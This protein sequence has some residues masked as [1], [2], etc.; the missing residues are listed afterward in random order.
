MKYS[1]ESTDR[2]TLLPNNV[3]CSNADS[4]IQHENAV[5][6]TTLQEDSSIVDGIVVAS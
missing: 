1:Q 2:R 5:A 4:Q 3:L 6:I